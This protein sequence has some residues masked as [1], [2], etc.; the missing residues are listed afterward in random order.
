MN[1]MSY[2]GY[3][4]R[5]EYS[6]EDELFIGR[7]AGIRDGVSFHAETVADLRAAFREAVDD[8]L[9]TCAKL[10]Q[11]PNKPYSGNLMIRVDPAV[12]AA[13]ARAAELAGKSLNAWAEEALRKSAS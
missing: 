10:G 8:Y 4:A 12:H 11:E 3:D 5:I 1:T 7:L 13:A 9:D 6:D 2:R